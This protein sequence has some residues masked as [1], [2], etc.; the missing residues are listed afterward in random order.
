[1]RTRLEKRAFA[2]LA[3]S[4]IV[5]L[6]Y[7]GFRSALRHT[8]EI[9]TD[10]HN[11]VVCILPKG[12]KTSSYE[13][14][15]EVLLR[16]RHKR[17]V[18]EDLQKRVHLLDNMKKSELT[19]TLNRRAL[20]PIGQMIYL[21]SDP[22]SVDP[23]VEIVADRVVELHK[24]SAR[25]IMAARRLGGLRPISE[26]LAAEVA[27]Q[28][29]EVIE[30][31]VGRRSLDEADLMRIAGVLRRSEAAESILGP[32]LDELP[33][34]AGARD[35][36]ARIRHGV[37]DWR[38]HVVPWSHVESAALLSGPPGVGK[39]YFAQALARTLGFKLVATSVGDWQRS[40][41]GYLGDTLKAMEASFAEA[42]AA[43]GAVLLIDELDSIGDR[44]RIGNAHR[45][46]ETTVVNALLEL[47]D[48]VGRLEG[49]IL[50]GATNYPDRIDPALRRSGRF[51]THIVLDPPTAQER[52]EI[53]SFHLGGRIRPEDM[54]TVT[55][56]FKRATAADLESL[57]K[58]ARSRARMR[59]SEVAL[60][61]LA[62][63]LPERIPIPEDVAYRI[64]VHEVGHAMV[65]VH[66]GFIESATIE[67]ET[68]A[69]MGQVDDLGRTHYSTDERIL[70]G[71]HFLTAKIR[72]LLA[73]MAAEEVVFGERSI[74]AG[75]V[76][77]SD[78]EQATKI[79]TAMAVSY[80]LGSSLR[81]DAPSQAVNESFRPSP[82]IAGD[83]SL[84]LRK[85]YQ[86]A[87]DVV[88][89]VDEEIRK[90]ARL[91]VVDKQ[92]ALER[93]QVLQIFNA[94]S[95]RSSRGS[96]R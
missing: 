54:R 22:S 27:T 95:A 6:A 4:P 2:D 43:K 11:T 83:V 20:R 52:A 15:A 88:L 30:M 5:F 7:A 34:F 58:R 47:T 39:T 24:P 61:D 19:K 79:A 85:E 57:A 93:K 68:T 28:S 29:M 21:A 66:T 73:G 90:F 26:A 50:L 13:H 76:I 56:H 40:K 72:T 59:Q 16:G 9:H 86:A 69:V 14:A 44:R 75:G 91:L 3:R 8:P 33:G 65:A 32:T 51:E 77:G 96:S 23:L 53:A 37:K 67:L 64:A 70:P 62:A 12:A 46:Y 25:Q 60:E 81:F 74:G 41:Q 36:V 17:F 18:Y 55:D 42:K 80:G 49:V 82:E 48:G 94:K 10:Q 84:I 38:A 35:W 78:L 92:I 1:M 89:M 31:A 63:E 45:Y 71:E 87:R